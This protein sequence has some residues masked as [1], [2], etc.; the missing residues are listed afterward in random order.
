MTVCTVM[1]HR[2]RSLTRSTEDNT[3]WDLESRT[4]TFQ[5]ISSF[6]D[7]RVRSASPSLLRW[8]MRSRMAELVVLMQYMMQRTYQSVGHASCGLQARTWGM[9]VCGLR[10]KLWVVRVR[11]PALL[12]G[13]WGQ[14][15]FLHLVKIS[16]TSTWSC[17]R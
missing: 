15:S 10:V 7:A 5:M 6:F 17:A 14:L 3:A 13:V 9:V 2:R 8:S 12:V 11:V 16:Y 1:P 4:N